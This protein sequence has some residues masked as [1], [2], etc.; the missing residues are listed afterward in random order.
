[1]NE[2]E[3]V[4]YLVALEVNILILGEE[5]RPKLK[6]YPRYKRWIT[7]PKELNLLI[8]ILVDV[9]RKLNL[10]LIWQLQ[11]KVVHFV[12]VLLVFINYGL[13]KPRE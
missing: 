8:P 3:N 4:P 5:L 7:V 13:F 1:L 10:K 11:N 9:Q 12:G 2:E 6:T